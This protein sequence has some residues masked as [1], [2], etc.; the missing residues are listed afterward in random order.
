[1]IEQQEPETTNT[2]YF[3]SNLRL[4]RKK[5]QWSQEEFATRVGLNRGNIASYENGSTEPKVYSLLKISELFQVSIKEL[6]FEDLSTFTHKETP[7]SATTLPDIDKFLQ[8]ARELEAVFKGLHTCCMFKTKQWG[9]EVPRDVHILVMHF[10]E[11]YQAAQTMLKE[12]QNLIS[13][14]HHCPH[15]EQ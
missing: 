14:V 15:N 4:L 5:W 3:A 2:N 6:V 10:E 7:I 1:M 13:K 12:H 11:L 9:E 8:R